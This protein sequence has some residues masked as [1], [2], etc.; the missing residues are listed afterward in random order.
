MGISTSGCPKWK[1]APRVFICIL[2]HEP[3]DYALMGRTNPRDSSSRWFGLDSRVADH[4][5]HV[6]ISVP[7][8][9]V[10]QPMILGTI[11]SPF[12]DC[13]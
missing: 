10:R 12:Q 8:L 7:P 2:L 9:D 6:R 1:K 5:R 11:H 13:Y 4:A 3:V